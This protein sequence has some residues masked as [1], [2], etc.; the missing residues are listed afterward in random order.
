MKQ[1]TDYCET[2]VFFVNGKKVIEKNASPET[3]LLQYLRDKLRLTGTKTACDQGGCGACTVMLSKYDVISK[4]VSH[5]TVTA[6]LIPICY[7]HGYS[8]T[9]VEGVGSTRNGLH[10]IQKSMVESYGLQCGF[11]TPGMIMTM[12]CLFRNNPKPTQQDMERALEGN[13]CRCTGYRP[14]IDAFKRCPM[15]DACCQNTK[16]KSEEETKKESQVSSDTVPADPSQDAIFPPELKLNS[17][18]NSKMAVF[19]CDG[20]IWFRPVTL[21]EVFNLLTQYPDATLMLGGTAVVPAI[22]TGALTKRAIICCT[23]VAEMKQIDKSKA[24]TGYQIGAAVTFRC[25]EKQLKEIQEK[26]AK[27]N[28]YEAVLSALRWIAV[29]Q[30]RNTA[31]IGGHVMVADPFSDLNPVLL[32]AGASVTIASK[33]GTREVKLDSSFF[34]GKFKTIVKP[35]EVLLSIFI[36]SSGPDFIQFHKNPNRR[37]YDYGI[38][39]AGMA[40]SLDKQ[41]KV[42]ELKLFFG[43]LGQTTLEANNVMKNAVSQTWNDQLLTSVSDSLVQEIS[44][45]IKNGADADKYKIALALGYFFKFYNHVKSSLDKTVGSGDQSSLNKLSMEPCQGLQIFESVPDDQPNS[46]GVGR[47]I[48]HVSSNNLVTGEARFVD[49]IPKYS[50]EVFVDF[51]ISSKAHAKILKVDTSKALEMEGVVGCIDS[52]DVPGSNKYGLMVHDDEL[53]KVDT[54]TSFGDVICGVVA[55]SREIARKAVKLVTVE[56]EE[57][58]PILSIEEAIEKNSMYP[59]MVPPKMKGDVEA[60]FKTSDVVLEGEVRCDRQEHF[61]LEPQSSLVVPKNEQNEVEV[62][63]SAQGANGVQETTAHFLNIPRSRIHVR[64]KRVG[65]AFGGKET[66]AFKPLGAAA[67][68]AYKFGRPARCILDRKTDFYI[69]GKRHPFLG[70]YKIGMKKDGKIEALLINI[71]ADGGNT[72]DMSAFVVMMSLIMVDGGYHFPNLHVFGH[73]CKTNTVSNTAFRGFGSPQG[74]FIIENIIEHVAKHLN[75]PSSEI[76]EINLIKDGDVTHYNKTLT[77]VNIGKCWDQCKRD[78]NFEQRVQEIQSFNRQNRWKK[79]GIAMM[80]LKF[81]CGYPIKQLNQAGA[82]LNVYLDGSILLAHGGTE[83]GQGLHTK[84]IQ[85]ASRALGVPVDDIFISETASNTVPNSTTTGGSTSADV[86]GAAVVNACTIL[87]ERL[88][89]FKDAKPDGTWKDWVNAAYTERV[90]LSVAGYAT[91]GEQGINPMTGE[92]DPWNYITYGAG[93]AE[94]EIDCLTGEHQVL[95][96]DL[97]MDVGKSLNPTIDIGQIEGGFVQGYGMMTMEKIKYTKEGRMISSGPMEYKIPGVRN[98]PREFKVALLKDCPNERAVYSSKGIGE[99]PFLLG[100]SAFLALKN[101]IYAAREEVGLNEYFR[102]DAPAIPEKI[103][104][105]CQDNIVKKVETLK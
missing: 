88:Q 74:V 94:V 83:C 78:S 19:H 4:K 55:E 11:C 95:K 48:P 51:V 8:V 31:T 64:I 86:N 73:I 24:G 52:K 40:L 85:V 72:V 104:M 66:S 6:C 89:P 54:V 84:M 21:K 68:A 35:G 87:K 29:D 70:K 77:N 30:I 53:F 50:D 33:R 96:A 27:S 82:F 75:R 14:I 38:V 10:P 23:H 99:P 43:G 81:P 90:S 69:T 36:P 41:Q 45:R 15:G 79:R 62:F 56:Y 105:A 18:I 22:K 57:M 9:T 67:V 28:I 39:N 32:A 26:G 102:F 101:A 63:C 37:G 5:F 46:D 7:V 3:T 17:D 80:P 100:I 47:P 16:A 12:Y 1:S 61:Y 97:V 34:I 25:L 59:P 58:E 76:K 60:G 44:K 2:L 42:K 91:P 49:D 92:G 20:W 65:G 103:R 71:Y 93:C 98:I 13:L